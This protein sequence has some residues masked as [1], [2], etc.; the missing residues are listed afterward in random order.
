[1]SMSQNVGPK[2]SSVAFIYDGS[3]ACLED[4]LCHEAAAHSEFCS[5]V[6]SNFAFE[7][8]RGPLKRIGNE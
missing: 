8:K 1:M 2:R 7:T 4:E 6:A 3:H 5:C